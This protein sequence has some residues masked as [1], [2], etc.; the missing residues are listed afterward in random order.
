[1]KPSIT[2]INTNTPRNDMW[3]LRKYFLVIF[4]I[5]A[6]A[7]CSKD[8]LNTEPG[9]AINDAAV[10][11]SE[12]YVEQFLFN[13]YFNMP[14]PRQWL[15]LASVTDEASF[16]QVD[17]IS[18]RVVE[19]NMTSEDMGAMG[20][21][22]WADG[23]QA[24]SWNNV[25]KR[26]RECN[27][28]FEKIDEVTFVDE[29]KKTNIKGEAYWL[30]AFNY[31]LLLK[32]FGGV[33]LVSQTFEYGPDED[34]SVSRNTF[35]ETVNFIVSDLDQAASILPADGVKTRATKGAALA[36]KSRVLLYA[37]SD[38]LIHHPCGRRDLRILNLS[39]TLVATRPHAG[40]LQKM[41][42]KP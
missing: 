40:R 36:L 18:T 27:L 29:S 39:D 38:L 6:L 24:W 12:A 13:I 31:F 16:I 34:Y 8:Y 17:G 11:K 21:A 30:R 19:S 1:M 33:P 2:N 26:I 28:L 15:E 5:A 32:Q 25:Y 4:L 14:F 10:W 9:N 23:Q 20:P 37:A 35:E 22:N 42:P 7:S 41:P 3:R